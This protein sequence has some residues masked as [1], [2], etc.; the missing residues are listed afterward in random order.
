MMA[1]AAMNSAAKGPV[2]AAPSLCEWSSLSSLSSW[3]PAAQ[4]SSG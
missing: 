4:L 1:I 3:P 2:A